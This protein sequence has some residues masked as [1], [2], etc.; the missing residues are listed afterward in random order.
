MKILFI[1]CACAL[2]SACST[3]KIETIE[4]PVF[5][6]CELN[7][8]EP[9]LCVDNAQSNWTINKKMACALNDIDVLKKHVS[10]LKK[11]IETCNNKEIKE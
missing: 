3:T 9:L 7:V 2:L 10:I 8:E 5:Q 1:L 6:Q 11:S 4:V